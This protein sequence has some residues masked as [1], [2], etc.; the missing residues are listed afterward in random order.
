MKFKIL[1]VDDDPMISDELKELLIDDGHEVQ[2]VN[3]GEDG[4]NT[5]EEQRFDIVFLDIKLPGID[6]VEVLKNIKTKPQSP[7]VIMIT[8]YATLET[9]I[10]SMR[11]GAFDYISKPFDIDQIHKSI[12][13]IIQ[14]DDFISNLARMTQFWWESRKNSFEMYI[15]ELGKSVGLCITKT[16][17]EKLLEDYNLTSSEFIWL[18]PE[19]SKDAQEKLMI[20]VPEEFAKDLPEEAKASGEVEIVALHPQNLFKLKQYLSSFIERTAE[21]PRAVI[22]FGIETL[23]NQHTWENFL[24]FISTI[25]EMLN[26]GNSRLIISVDPH[27]MKRVDFINLKRFVSRSNVDMIADSLS[28]VL[29]RG[30]IQILA[31]KSTSNF[32]TFLKLL[33]VDDSGKLGFHLRKLISDGI[34]KKD[35]E[36]YS[37]TERGLVASNILSLLEEKGAQDV[38]NVIS[39]TIETSH[40]KAE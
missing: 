27:D 2:N 23:I 4:L 39:M 8:G 33:E 30:I 35:K 16:H 26:L 12:D 10:E 9:A 18:N 32:S 28:N 19:L 15:S 17:P 21:Q 36:L 7:Y 22:F 20:K 3:S 38:E 13:S 1:I 31:D 11:S 40:E 24:K 25:T 14:E 6:G 34:I 5:L 37:L 29:R